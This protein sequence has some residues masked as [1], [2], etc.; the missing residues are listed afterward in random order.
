MIVRSL[1]LLNDVVTAY[2]QTKTTIQGRVHS[3]IIDSQE[4]LGPPIN[5]FDD[6]FTDAGVTMAG[7][8]FLSSFLTGTVAR[9]FSIIAEAAGAADLVL[10]NL[11]TATGES[12]YVGKI[13]INLPDTAASTHTYRGLRVVDSGTTGWKIFVLTTTAAGVTLINGGLFMVNSVDLVDFAP[14]GFP[15]IPFATG[16]NQKAV[17]D[18][19]DASFI[20]SAH[21]M[22]ASAGMFLDTANTMVY[23][24][25][26][27]AAT[28][29]YYV[30]DYSVAPTW[31]SGAVDAITAA[32]DTVT[33]TGHVFV[34]ADPVTFTS[35][36]TAGLT[37]GTVYFVIS[38]I[39]GVSYQLSATSGGAAINIT[40][41]GGGT[42]GR[43]FG[44]SSNNFVHKTGNLTALTGTLL[45]N[46]SEGYA[47]PQHSSNAGFPC[48]AFL[49]TTNLYF[50]KL[51]ELTAGATAWT[52]LVTANVLGPTSEVTAPTPAFG[53]WSQEMDSF[54]YVTNTSLF[55]VKKL[56]NNSLDLVYG[57]LNTTFLET[58]A[59]ETPSLGLVT[60]GGT[61]SMHGWFMVS[62]TT[63]GQRVI[64]SN[65]MYSNSIFDYSYIVSKVIDTSKASYKFI[66]TLEKIFD[67]TSSSIFQ[68]RTSGFGS[69][70][71]GW[72]TI[73]VADDLSHIASG[74]ETQ[75]KILFST[76]AEPD[77]NPS[78]LYDLLLA[79]S[80]DNENSEHWVGSHPNTISTSPAKSAFR[81]VKEYDIMVPTLYFRAY[82]DSGTLVESADTLNDPTLFEYSTN[83][84][85]SW[86][87]L[88][89]IS[90]TENTTE[91]R[92]LW[93]TDP[94]LKV[95][96]SIREE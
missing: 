75:F 95:T 24:H 28:H 19:Q 92:Y 40:T 33:H 6:V 48:A 32:T 62:G 63:V 66:S 59:S 52:S 12:T 11:D 7:P 90:N 30:F 20:G 77:G 4:V 89:T 57:S 16:N 37:A 68:Y 21:L 80:L 31:A 14:I 22:T 94:G 65:D 46:N 76:E 53:S 29:Q 72:T 1:E 81:L 17:Y 25:N 9:K 71:G 58:S 96:V 26:G 34:N 86:I 70:S 69:I 79:L 82:D 41:D 64:V 74:D 93:S 39:A 43:A 36:T 44:T 47:T 73:S 15:T 8:V 35:V 13:R 54:I 61:A 49:T 67:L 55:Y 87:P 2:D 85:T 83:N 50:G 84:G 91:L 23:V 78:Q 56:V 45:L 27:I 88:G 60:V 18:L 51:S 5:S 10:Y 42:I 38:S 3:K